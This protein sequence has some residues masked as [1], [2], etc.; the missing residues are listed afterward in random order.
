MAT[1]EVPATTASTEP[2]AA[3]KGSFPDL[4]RTRRAPPLRPG[5][6]ASSSRG[7]PPGHHTE[8]PPT[9]LYR[10]FY[11]AWEIGNMVGNLAVTAFSRLPSVHNGLKT[12]NEATGG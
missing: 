2:A 6:H 7:D 4:T 12:E 11:L 8:P 3:I 10:A 1:T 5:I 9:P